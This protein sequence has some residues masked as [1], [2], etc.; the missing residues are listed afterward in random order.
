MLLEE[1][2]ENYVEIRTGIKVEKVE[3]INENFFK[4][5]S[6]KMAY[7]LGF[8][9]ADGSLLNTYKSSRTFYLSLS[10]NDYPLLEKIRSTLGSNHNIYSRG[11]REINYRNQRY[12]SKPGYVLRV[13][14]KVIYQ[15][16]INIGIQHKKSNIMKLPDI[17]KDYLPNFARGY[18]DGD[19]CI[20]LYMPKGRNYP[21]IKVLFTS[22]IIDFLDKLDI[23]IKAR[24]R[25]LTGHIQHR[26]DFASN[27]IYQG[28][29][30]LKVLDFIY[31]NLS[32][33]P[34]LKYKHDL[35]M[36]YKNNLIGPR[37]KKELAI[38]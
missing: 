32:Y 18:F 10:N 22:G 36:D 33:V 1:C 5:W 31:T 30:A 35:Y 3:K 37:V 12:A 27:L 25:I 4:L 21:T 15:D 38:I 28:S 14:S 11:P 34:F 26:P 16:L 9:Y 13:G 17:P 23:S 19:G 7:V 29:S 8:I 20:S 6:P 2:Q 24:L